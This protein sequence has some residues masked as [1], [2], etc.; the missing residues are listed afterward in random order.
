MIKVAYFVNSFNVINWGGQATSNGIKYQVNKFYADA[1]FKPIIL[2]VPGYIFRKIKIFRKFFEIRLYNAMMQGN[3]Q[4]IH[5]ALKSY[6]IEEDFFDGFSHICFNGEGAIRSGSGHIVFYLGLLYKAKLEGRYVAAFNQT[7]DL[8]ESEKLAKLVE[9]VYNMVDF[10]GARE[11]LSYEHGKSIGIKGL[12]LI[13]DAVYGLPVMSEDDINKRVNSYNLPK[14]YVTFAGSSA[15]KRDNKS[16]KKVA[17]I[18]EIVDKKFNLPILFLANAKTDI[19]LAHQLQS[20]YTFT[21][22]EPPVKYE[23]AMAIIAKSEILIGGRQH[24]NIFAFIYKTKYVPFIG[25]SFKNAGVAKLQDYPLEPLLWECTEDELLKNI[26]F[27]V[28]KDEI[29]KD[30][31]IETFK[32]LG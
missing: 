24:P 10:V 20:K 8:R 32:A 31:K 14:K 12:Q 17:N 30:I 25:N 22:V 16:L 13:P 1:I 11:P 29:F 21:I 3:E 7:I 23:D 19:W 15:L 6:F 4:K 18:L 26:D 27:I 28:A 2:P 9:K 5:F